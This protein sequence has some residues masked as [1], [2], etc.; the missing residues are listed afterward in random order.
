MNLF[1]NA[2]NLRFGGGITFTQQLLQALLPLRKND[3]ITIVVPNGAG[4]ES[5]AQTPNVQLIFVPDRFHYSRISKY[6]YNRSVFEKWAKQANAD[7]IISLGNIA[8]PSPGIT[9]LLLI[10][11]AFLFYPESPAW[12]RMN[13]RQFTYNRM[14]NAY[15][16]KHL[17]FA[18]A[19]AVQTAVM[20]ERLCRLFDIDPE[21]VSIVP[22]AI[23]HSSSGNDNIGTAKND[24]IRLL[25]LS[26]YY[27]HKN[28]EI[29]L[30]L[31]K[32]IKQQKQNI[33]ITLTL[34]ANESK[35]TAAF[36]ETI[37]KEQL[38]DVVKNRGHVPLAEI[39]QTFHYYDGL[40]FPTLLESFSGTYLEAMKSG[41]PIFTSRFDF[42][43]HLC[44]DAAFYFNPLDARS[45]LRTITDA[46]AQPEAI[47]A[48]VGKGHEILDEMPD[49]QRV[50]QSFSEII[51]RFE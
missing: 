23:A 12:S 17:K 32:E 34:D 10:Q 18:S 6:Y 44:K 15:T 38:A 7:K 36:L 3:Q 48:K 45:I 51:D 49:W 39:E 41:K 37:Q 19:Y 4:Y 22:N 25:V 31:A 33:T 20:K 16:A 26:K 40:L 9:Q 27:A 46:F 42:A 14:M 47:I 43:T 21:K 50:A 28:F 2:S 5:L 8:F 30:P 1:F 35:D 11:N 29:L 13:I 24:G